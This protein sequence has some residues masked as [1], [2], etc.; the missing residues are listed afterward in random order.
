MQA[1]A[2]HGLFYRCTTDVNQSVVDI[3]R[4]VDSLKVNILRGDMGHNAR[5]ELWSLSK[6]V[7]CDDSNLKQDMSSVC[8]YNVLG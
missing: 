1:A 8:W 3:E 5:G 7:S 6:G 2:L 4:H